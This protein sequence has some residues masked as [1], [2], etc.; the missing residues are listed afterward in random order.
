[1]ARI[2]FL[3]DTVLFPSTDGE[4]L[5]NPILNMYDDI[6]HI[7]C[8]L[9]APA[10][11]IPV[12]RANKLGHEFSRNDIWQVHKAKID[13]ACLANNHT[14]DCGEEGLINTISECNKYGIQTVGASIDKGEAYKPIVVQLSN[15]L[16]IAVFSC[17]HRH[18]DHTTV[19]FA[20]GTAYIEDRRLISNILS[21]KKKVDIVVVNAHCGIENTPIPLQ[22]WREY[23][24]LLIDIG[25]DIIIGHHTHTVQGIE[26]YKGKAIAYSLGNFAFDLN[27]EHIGTVDTGWNDYLAL[28]VD[29]RPDKSYEIECIK[30]RYENHQISVNSTGRTMELAWSSEDEYQKKYEE[31]LAENTF[32]YMSIIK[33]ACVVSPVNIP[34]LYHYIG[35]D[36][37]RIVFEEILERL[38]ANSNFANYEAN[39]FEWHISKYI[40]WGTG[41]TG[42]NTY[43]FLKKKGF[44]VDGF[45][46]GLEHEHSKIK[47][48]E[49]VVEVCIPPEITTRPKQ[50]IIIASSYAED[51]KK[52]ID[53]LGLKNKIIL[54]EELINEVYMQQAF[55]WKYMN[56][57]YSIEK[58][59]KELSYRVK[60]NKG[61]ENAKEIV[62]ILHGAGSCG[63]DNM[64]PIPALGKVTKFIDRMTNDDVAVVVPQ[65]PFSRKWI[66]ADYGKGCYDITE[67]NEIPM[68]EEILADLQEELKG[69]RLRLFG[70]SLGAFASWYLIW[71][72]P[73]LFK[74]ALLFS[75]AGDPFN[76]NEEITTSVCLVHSSDDN[77]VP[78]S[79]SRKMYEVYQNSIDITYEEQIGLGHQLTH[80]LTDEAMCR[81]IDWL[82]N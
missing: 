49:D 58:K 63:N 37:Q 41:E 18:Y 78:V 31:L 69:K 59:G 45:V 75:G 47:I 29:F 6:E 65:C 54:A 51:I 4:Q 76:I 1:M 68:V 16:R 48:D 23:Y 55:A 26:Y 25:A 38:N 35:I 14:F 32:S 7:C 12:S 67:V 64:L 2:L 52:T 28:V 42:K 3:G 66:D 17:V 74:K 24:K 11:G 50:M 70:F 40:I 33:R 34:V 61:V 71:K 39:G 27:D 30:G 10:Y 82:L 9:E 20:A 53:R 5:M 60:C 22:H 80:N 36:T 15:G 62:L 46:D 72:Y 56:W 44:I 8:N 19:M 57:N 77:I 21:F 81:Y 43:R 13:I 73:K 79:G